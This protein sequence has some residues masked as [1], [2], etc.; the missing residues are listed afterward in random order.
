MEEFDFDDQEQTWINSYEIEDSNLSQDIQYCIFGRNLIALQI[1]QGAD[2]RGGYTAPQVFSFLSGC[3]DD[4]IFD[5]GDFELN[6]NIRQLYYSEL[7][8]YGSCFR[9]TYDREEWKNPSKKDLLFIDKNDKHKVYLPYVS[10]EQT[11]LEL[12]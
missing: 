1:H 5:I 2:I 12:S 10:E 3:D 4:F 11:A 7:N 8:G 6:D 9:A